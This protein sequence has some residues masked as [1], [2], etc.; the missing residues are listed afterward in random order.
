MSRSDIE[1]PPSQVKLRLSKD[2]AAMLDVH[3]HLQ[4]AASRE[5]MSRI[6]IVRWSRFHSPGPDLTAIDG[7]ENVIG[8]A[9]VKILESYQQQPVALTVEIDAVTL[10]EIRDRAD[11]EGVR[12]EHLAS[13]IVNEHGEH[14][15]D[16]LRRNEAGL[17]YIPEGRK[18]CWCCDGPAALSHRR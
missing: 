13:A 1:E 6:W 5:E 17:A 14:Q 18:A 12:V 8:H 7:S 16:D 4:F 10:K 15:A 2:T 9:R 11:H 3:C